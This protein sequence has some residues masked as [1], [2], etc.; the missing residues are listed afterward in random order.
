MTKSQ[1]KVLL[2]LGFGFGVLVGIIFSM[3]LFMRPSDLREYTRL[4]DGAGKTVQAVSKGGVGSS[5]SGRRVTSSLRYCTS[6]RYEIDGN[7]RHFTDKK[8]CHVNQ[9]DA[10]SGTTA[11]LI[12][13]PSDLGTIFVHSDETLN[14]LKGTQTA[15][16][17][18]SIIGL[19]V[20]PSSIAGLVVVNRRSKK[21]TEQK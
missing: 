16:R 19:V 21:P 11:E 13:D 3:F 18:I 5:Q 1:K 2:N 20:L 10:K 8:D 9:E 7:E 17:V 15:F 6:W 4:T 12:Y 14:K